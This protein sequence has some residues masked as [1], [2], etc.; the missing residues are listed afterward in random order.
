[1]TSSI[2]A[3]I[4][5]LKALQGRSPQPSQPVTPPA[6]KSPPKASKK[7]DKR[8]PVTEQLPLLATP[9]DATEPECAFVHPIPIYSREIVEEGQAVTALYFNR[10]HWRYIGCCWVNDG[11]WYAKTAGS[12]EE[13]LCG[14]RDSAMRQVIQLW[15][16]EQ[17]AL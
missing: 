13:V 5:R 14:D 6:P 12:F 15:I 9:E 17:E 1:M 7:K 8:S 11:Q 3:H 10:A 16:L 2:Q 4:D